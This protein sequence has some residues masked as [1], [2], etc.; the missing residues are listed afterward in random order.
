MVIDDET[1]ICLCYTANEL[2]KGAVFNITEDDRIS[3]GI[4]D[5]NIGGDDRTSY[6]AKF[7][8][9]GIAVARPEV[10]WTQDRFRKRRMRPPGTLNFDRRYE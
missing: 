4:G 8:T 7:E 2:W 6:C 3:I 10:G 1:G 9:E 5:Y